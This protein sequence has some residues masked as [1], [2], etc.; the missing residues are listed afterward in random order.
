[1]P[2]E[3]AALLATFDTAYQAR[4]GLRYPFVGGKEAKLMQGLLKLYTVPQIESFIAAFFESHDD[5]IVGSGFSFGAF[6]GCLP[7]VIASIHE[8]QPSKLKLLNR[9]ERWIDC[10]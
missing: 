1:M 5:F 6:K 2:S 3:I 4:L 8:K 9:G 7:K 10:A